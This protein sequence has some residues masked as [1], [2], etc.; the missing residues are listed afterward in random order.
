MPPHANV[1][2]R[3]PDLGVLHPNT[4]RTIGVKIVSPPRGAVA[5]SYVT[6]GEFVRV[7]LGIICLDGRQVCPLSPASHSLSHALAHSPFR[8]RLK[9]P[10]PCARLCGLC[11][12]TGAE[13]LT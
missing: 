12:S 10:H 7:S 5:D 13:K 6:P 9:P 11:V 8:V 2:V 1:S 4:E 3:R